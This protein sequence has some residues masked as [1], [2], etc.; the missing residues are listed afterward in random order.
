MAGR[1]DNSVPDRFLAPIDCLKIPALSSLSPSSKNPQECKHV[2]YADKG[3]N[4]AHEFPDLDV[5]L[6]MID[7]G[8]V[9][10]YRA[11]LCT[12]NPS[13]YNVPYLQV[14]FSLNYFNS[15][16]NLLVNPDPETDP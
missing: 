11:Y 7:Q 9:Q 10:I 14:F 13:P 3:E 6:I 2:L 16:S 15:K 12:S 1:F 8:R 4:T 5:D